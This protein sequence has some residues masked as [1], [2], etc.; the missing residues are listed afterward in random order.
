MFLVGA[1]L[2]IAGIIEAFVSP[3]LLAAPLKL[4]VGV[5]T[6]ALL[7]GYILLG[8]SGPAERQRKRFFSSR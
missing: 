5:S 3:T 7:W 2:T 8:G 1:T 4:A 6:G